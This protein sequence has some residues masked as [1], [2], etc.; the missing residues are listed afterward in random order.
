MNKPS[1]SWVPLC[2]FIV[3]QNKSWPRRAEISQTGADTAPCIFSL[4][5]PECLE[6]LP[7]GKSRFDCEHAWLCTIHGPFSS[8]I[9]HQFAKRTWVIAFYS[10]PRLV[11]L[12]QEHK[13]EHWQ[14]ATSPHHSKSHT[15]SARKFFFT[16]ETR[17]ESLLQIS[18]GNDPEACI[19]SWV[20]EY[21]K[22]PRFA[23]LVISLP[24][25]RKNPEV[26]ISHLTCYNPQKVQHELRSARTGLP[27]LP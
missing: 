20:H 3:V 5:L 6:M 10:V 8:Q 12:L 19:C 26:K 15:S 14:S 22:H 17:A 9:L 2:W 7:F 4:V 25:P 23:L 24:T 18:S 1:Q 21:H 11:N 27:R 16:S 13:K